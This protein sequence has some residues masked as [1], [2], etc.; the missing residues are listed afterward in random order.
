VVVN[1]TLGPEGRG[2]Y[3]VLVT[4]G[5]VALNLGHLSIEE[6]HV[7]LWGRLR[8]S[9]AVTANSILF[10]L[11]LGGLCA[12]IAGIVVVA[13]GPGIVPVPDHLLLAVALAWIPCAM[14]EK[15][16][17]RVMVLRARIEVNN[18]SGLL[19]SSVHCAA[20]L[21]LAATG[22]LTLWWV[23]A[24]WTACAAVP[25]VLLIPAA[26]PRLM[27]RDIRLARRTLR[28]GLRYHIG[29]VSVFLLLR[30]DIL[31]LNAMTTTEAVGLYAVAVTVMEL[32]RVPPDVIANIVMPRQLE[33]DEESAAAV[34]VRATRIAAL[35][36]TASVAAMCAAA[37][38]VVP[39]L[40]G[41]S[42]AGSVAPL[43][44]LAPGLWMIGAS[45]PVGAFLLRLDRP[46][47]NSATAAFALAV[48]VGLNLVL[49]PSFGVVGSAL[50]SSIGYGVLAVLQIAWFVRA[51]RIPARHLIPRRS[52][53]RHVWGTACRTALSMVG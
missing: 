14:T 53:V 33:H 15:L 29:L 11:A 30:A 43:L 41:A 48:N 40:Y 9:A 38:F 17:A 4:V 25:L 45:R 39:M 12:V 26:G 7:S 50:A 47:L 5:T 3:A 49:I 24:L 18:R 32:S 6:S 8:D 44:G 23:V 10:G 52:D 36:A 28:I 16:L 37:P 51:T 13:L 27:D 21:L 1:R 42:F 19:S 2:A 20:L 34:T 22:R 31:I 46:S 35:V